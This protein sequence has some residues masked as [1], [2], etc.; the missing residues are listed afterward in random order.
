MR[1]DER[2]GDDA[3]TSPARRG[4]LVIDGVLLASAV[5]LLIL[6][7]SLNETARRFPIGVLAVSVVLLVVDL[8]VELV[9]SLRDRLRPIDA[10]LIAPPDDLA[11]TAKEQIGGNAQSGTAVG[12]RTA[13]VWVVGFGVA[14]YVFGYRVA[15][16]LAVAAF[17]AYLKVPVRVWVPIVTVLALLN[18]FVL[19]E[20]F[21]LR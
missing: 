8:A 16:P 10:G 9:P 19:Y 3:R 15:G 11:G 4:V 17:S 12:E 7:V 2:A 18:H 5:T 6:A 14:M 1:I 13:L 20:L 21:T